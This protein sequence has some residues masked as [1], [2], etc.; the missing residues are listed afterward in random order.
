MPEVAAAKLLDELDLSVTVAGAMLFAAVAIAA[1]FAYHIGTFVRDEWQYRR[2]VSAARSLVKQEKADAKATAKVAASSAKTSVDP[3]AAQTLIRYCRFCDV[4]IGDE[5]MEAHE[6]GKKHRK[7]KAAAGSL[8]EGSC[9]IWRP[10]PALMTEMLQEGPP[11]VERIVPNAS[12][13]SA[14]K[15]TGAWSTAK[16]R[17]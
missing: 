7:L 8:A 6:A 12:A 13:T 11:A 4:P 15:G 14:G 9:W 10:A 5:F 17:K 2:S 1:L 16:R 3:A